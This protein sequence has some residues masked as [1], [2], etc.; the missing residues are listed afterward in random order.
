MYRRLR[1]IKRLQTSSHAYNV[2]SPTDHSCLVYECLTNVSA[3]LATPIND[4]RHFHGQSAHASVVVFCSWRTLL[5]L[6]K[7][8]HGSICHRHSVTVWVTQVTITQV[9]SWVTLQQSLSSH[10]MSHSPIVTLKSQHESLSN[11]HSQVTAW[12]T[13]QQWH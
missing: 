3:S 8:Q 7:S 5:Q 13:L 11:S 4:Y 9:T 2:S 10:S 1:I 6:L 12:V